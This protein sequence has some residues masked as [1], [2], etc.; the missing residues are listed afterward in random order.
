M[1][2]FCGGARAVWAGCTSISL[3]WISDGLLFQACN[4]TGAA[5]PGTLRDIPG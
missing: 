1:A 2:V 3:G 4:L 5:A